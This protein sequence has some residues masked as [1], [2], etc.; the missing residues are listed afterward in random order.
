MS[1]NEELEITI[2]EDGVSI[3]AFGYVGQDCAVDVDKMMKELDA[4]DVTET[5]KKEYYL[6][7]RMTKVKNKRK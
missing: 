5:K 3:E 2:D 6:K 4:K 7:E 1:K